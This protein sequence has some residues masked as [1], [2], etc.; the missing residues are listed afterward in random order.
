VYLEQ[1]D[2]SEQLPPPD[3]AGAGAGVAAAPPLHVLQQR[4]S[5]DWP[6]DVK[7]RPQYEDHPEQKP[8]SLHDPPLLPPG[9]GGAGV[10]AGTGE[11]V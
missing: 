8:G 2:S 6:P 3:G 4:V 1:K 10:G 7:P 9:G 11:E 5:T